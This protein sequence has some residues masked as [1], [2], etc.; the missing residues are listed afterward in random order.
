MRKQCNF[1]TNH[2]I[3]PGH[4]YAA[5]CSSK[6]RSLFVFAELSCLSWPRASISISL[7]SSHARNLS[8]GFARLSLMMDRRPITSTL[9]PRVFGSVAQSPATAKP[10]R[11]DFRLK[12]CHVFANRSRPNC[13]PVWFAFP[14]TRPAFSRG[15]AHEQ[16]RDGC[17]DGPRH[18]RASSGWLHV[19]IRSGLEYPVA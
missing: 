12:F 17:V 8:F 2:L 9:F 4:P 1:Y 10:R 5:R 15:I 7:K 16:L 13:S 3:A 19:E 18:H 14:L 6:P 11:M